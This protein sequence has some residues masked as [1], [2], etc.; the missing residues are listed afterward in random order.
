MA[1][2]R[3]SAIAASR[4]TLRAIDKLPPGSRERRQ[5]QVE[6]DL[7]TAP[8]ALHAKGSVCDQC[9]AR[10]PTDSF[11]F[12]HATDAAGRLRLRLCPLCRKLKT[13]S[14]WNLKAWDRC[15]ECSGSERE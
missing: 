9:P 2:R 5:A 13:H 7:V 15:L 10:Y 6:F 8:C 11:G 12:P 1:A 3:Q 4:A 14:E